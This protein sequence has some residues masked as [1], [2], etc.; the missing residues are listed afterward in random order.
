MK[1][2]E[3]LVELS[4]RVDLKKWNEEEEN[5]WLALAKDGVVEREDTNKFLKFGKY[6]SDYFD[7]FGKT[8]TLEQAKEFMS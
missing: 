4:S 8:P 1:L 5:I 2:D 3:I 6:F 7:E